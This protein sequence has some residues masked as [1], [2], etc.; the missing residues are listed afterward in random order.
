[1]EAKST[2]EKIIIESLK[3]FSRDGFEATSTRTIAR[4]INASDAVIY[5]HFKSKQDILDAII[6]MCSQRLLER[7]TSVD[8]KS[9][10]WDGVEKICMDMFEFQ[11]TDEL[12]VPFRKLLLIEQFKNEKL[13]QLYREVFIEKPLFHMEKIFSYLINEGHMKNGNPKVFA[14]ELYSPFLMFHTYGDI[15]EEIIQKLKDHVNEFRNNVLLED[16]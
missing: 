8:V 16:K 13:Q 15:T 6:E 11:T 5:K 4:S 10:S 12:I 1:M 9:M 3:L 2:K 7:S 14:M